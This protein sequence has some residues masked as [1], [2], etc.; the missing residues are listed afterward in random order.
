MNAACLKGLLAAGATGFFPEARSMQLAIQLMNKMNHSMLKCLFASSLVLFGLTNAWA[1]LPVAA[2]LQKGGKIADSSKSS[3]ACPDQFAGTLT[4]G[5][6]FGQSNDI[7]PDT[8]YLCRNDSIKIV[9]N[10]DEDLSGDPIAMTPPGITYGFFDCPPTVSGPNLSSILTDPCLTTDPPPFG[11]IWITAN[12]S[13]NGNITFSNTGDLQNFFNGG[14]PLM[15]WFAPLTIDNFNNNT[16]ENDPITGESGPC[17]HLNADAAFAVVYLNEIKINNFE[18]TS[19]ISGCEGQFQISGGLPEFEPSDYQISISLLNDPSVIATITSGTASNGET[20]IFQVPVP[21]L[22]NIVVEDGKSCG[23][24]LL[25][26]LGS[27]ITLTQ[28]MPDVLAAPADNI[29]IDVVNESGWDDIVSIQYALTWDETVLQYQNV[30]NLTPFIPG[31]NVASSFNSVG[32]SLLF[33]WFSPSGTGVTLANGIVL[34]QV[35]FNVIGNNGDCTDLT[36]A[37]APIIEVVNE[38]GAQIGF[39]GQAGSVCVSSGAL[40]LNTAAQNATCPSSFNGSI[41]ANVDGGQPPYQVT[42]QNSLG[43]PVGGPGVINLNGGTF[44]ISNLAPGSY[45]VSVSDSQQPPFLTN[46]TV[47]VGA[48]PLPLILFNNTLPVCNAG[49]GTIAASL[50]LNG[51]PLPNPQQNYNFN[52]SNGAN[53]PVNANLLSGNYALTVTEINSGCTTT[54]SVFLLQPPPLEAS[55]SLDSVSCSGAADGSIGVIVSGGTP[56]AGGNYLIAWISQGV[57]DQDSASFLSGLQSGAY[58]LAVTDNNGCT[59]QQT[60]NLPA[61]KTIAVNAVVNNASCFGS[62]NGNIFATALTSGAAPAVPYSFAWSGSPNPPP[63]VNTATTTAVNNLCAGIYTLQVSDQL[64]CSID[65]TFTISSPPPLQASVLSIQNE[66]CLSGADGSITLSVSGGTYPY[67]YQW[68]IANADSVASGLS[69]GSYSVTIADALGCTAILSATVT[70]IPGPLITA[71]PNDVL[72]CANSTDGSLSVSATPGSAPITSYAWSNNA[73]GPSITGLPTGTYTVTITDQAGCTST[74]SAQ[75][76]APLPLVI[77]SL[78]LQSPQCPGQ[79]GGSIIAFVAGGTSPYQFQWS[80]GINGINFNVISNLQAGTFTLTVTDAN[81]CQPLTQDV[82][83]PDPPSI[84]AVFTGVDSV[85]CANS[86]SDCDGT[87]TALGAY[88]DGSSGLFTFTWQS[89]ES[90]A[91]AGSS[92]ASNLCAGPQSLIISDGTCFIDTSVLVPSPPPIVPGQQITNV[93]CNGLSDG[94]ITLQPT[95]GTPPYSIN[96]VGGPNGP[97]I[98]GLAAGNYSALI[99]DA[100]NCTFTHTVAV[101]QPQ[102]FEVLLNGALTTDVSCPGASDGLLS[103]AVQG[104]N[105]NLGPVVYLWQNG[106]APINSATASGLMP[107]TYSVTV[108]DIKG[109]ADSLTYSIQQP[110]PIQFKLGEIAPIPC[111]GENTFITVDSIWGGNPSPYTFSVNNGLDKLPGEFVPVLAGP[112]LITITDALLGCTVDTTLFIQEPLEISIQLPDVVEIDLGDSLTTLD[113]VIVSSLPIE[114]FTWEPPDQLS[115]ADCKNPRVTPVKN[116]RY[117]LTIVDVNGCSASATVLVDLDRNRNIYIPNVFSPNGD[118]I[119]DKFKVF[120]GIGISNINF[121]RLYDRWGGKLFEETN[122]LPDPD[123]TPGWDGN[124]RGEAMKPGVY[125]YLV[126]VEFLDGQVLLYRGDVTLLR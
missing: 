79:G 25:A 54:S 106:I 47:Q 110:P 28:T 125:L 122:L 29:C 8:L 113:P 37:A 30:A 45:S 60:I 72:S 81:N 118:G 121:I 21:G 15:L 38:S 104:G 97:T 101:I 16:F 68:N 23:A 90:T 119:N 108:V 86:G 31:F 124:F 14:D 9:H 63:G 44:T 105:I 36:F 39:N 114:S 95:G 48:P 19:G 78:D 43:G 117:T 115:C 103:V 51:S 70:K 59:L 112:H 1:Q 4:F 7:S 73:S 77:D 40:V 58:P 126:E 66:S 116:Q 12:G 50:L 98:S 20:V 87:A 34:F 27:C 92:S 64:G 11:G 61:L 84:V 65:T 107:G 102:A 33:S 22:Y 17:V 24:S 85:S 100:K 57:V 18:V 52:W 5:S 96:W 35:C 49:S 55:I 10:G 41:T 111:F 123:G 76:T 109:C 69:A 82:V 80:N 13:A 26:N 91:N 89:G 32:D 62:C 94:Q 83:L 67:N 46:E 71:L 53:S 3:L 75:V 56:S 42:W 6:F 88:S 93:T 74:A 120:S 2:Q 99:T